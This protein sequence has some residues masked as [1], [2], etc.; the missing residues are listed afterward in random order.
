[1]ELTGNEKRIMK[2]LL[3][4]ARISD[5][6]IA[7][8]LNISSQA[9]GRIRKTLEK[10]LIKSYSLEFNFLKAG[11]E[12]FFMGKLKLTTEGIEFGKNKVEEQLINN[13]NFF[14]LYELLGENSSYSFVA[15]FKDLKE[16]HLFFKSK[17]NHEKFL[18]YVQVTDTSAL[19]LKG[20]LKHDIKPLLIKIIGDQKTKKEKIKHT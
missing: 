1:M 15:A 17:E 7:N 10:K 20:M 11:I 13:E 12:V 5:T 16:L 18:K 2:L 9:V 19:P 8:K 3:E 4:N 6:A 14:C